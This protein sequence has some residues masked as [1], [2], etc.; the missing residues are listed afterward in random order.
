LPWDDGL[1]QVFRC[2]LQ[3]YSKR[4]RDPEL[5][6]VLAPFFAHHA[7]DLCL[8]HKYPSTSIEARG[9]L[10]GLCE[11]L[12]MGTTFE[13]ALARCFAAPASPEVEST[14]APLSA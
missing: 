11:D 7:L 12:L 5:Y 13:T 3:R 6:Q 10:L 1:G 8:P 14:R 4:A 2:F 9:R